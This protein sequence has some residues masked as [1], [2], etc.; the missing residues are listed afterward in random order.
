MTTRDEIIEAMAVHMAAHD[1]M[2]RDLFDQEEQIDL[3][4]AALA[5]AVEMGVKVPE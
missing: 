1:P 3:A 5:A 2:F 4:E